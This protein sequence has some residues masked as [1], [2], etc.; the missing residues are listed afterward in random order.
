[1]SI[2]S[3]IAAGEIS[4]YKCAEDERFYAF[5]DINPVAKGHTLVV[6]KREVD[7]IFDMEDQELADMTVFAK[8]VAKAM[9]Q[10]L[11]CKKIGVA[12][13][14]LEVPHAHM[15]LIPLQGE[16]DMDFKKEKLRLP[17]EDMQHI[18]DRIFTAF[19]IQQ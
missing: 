2:F 11:P 14:G 3:K 13:L 6:P 4:S 9:K 16:G 18:A 10:V 12:V 7:Y 17:E 8:R 1:M 19:S 5:L 15:H